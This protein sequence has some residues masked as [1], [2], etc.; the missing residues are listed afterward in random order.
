[1]P[2]LEALVDRFETEANTKVIGISVDSRYSH[3]NWAW[4]LGGISYPLLA[5]FQPRGGVASAYGVFLQEAGIT[6]RAT[7]IVDTEGI[8]QF[9]E[10]VGPGGQRDIRQLLERA[11]QVAAGK[12]PTQTSAPAPRKGLSPDATLYMREGCRFCAGVLRAAAN[13]HCVDKLRIRDVERSPEA[14]R[15][16]DAIAGAGSKVP[17]LVQGGQVTRESGTIIQALA[18]MYARV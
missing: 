3:A 18:E 4:D 13:L 11:K 15:E 8:V 10:S 14:R 16:L 1:M 17:V 9:A 6:D 12:T 2:A 7:I 5:D